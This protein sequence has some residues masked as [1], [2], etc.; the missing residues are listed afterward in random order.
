MSSLLLGQGKIEGERG[1]EER[2]EEERGER[3]ETIESF[4]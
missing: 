3:R 4:L 1:E 2:G